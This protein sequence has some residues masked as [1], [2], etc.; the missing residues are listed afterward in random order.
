MEKA[1]PP[2]KRM[3]T[4]LNSEVFH[5]KNVDDVYIMHSHEIFLDKHL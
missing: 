2:F 3:F 5:H 1:K 4:I